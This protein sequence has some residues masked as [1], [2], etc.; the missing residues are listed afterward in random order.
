M[1]TNTKNEL[2]NYLKIGVFILWLH[3]L[4]LIVILS[5]CNEE[6]S[7]KVNEKLKITC[8]TGFVA[9][10]VKNI[11]KDK[12]NICTLMGAGVDPHLYKATQG[13]IAKLNEADI[14]VYN[15]LHLEGKMTDI[16]EK[17]KTRKTIIAQAELI[18]NSNLLKPDGF[19]NSFDPHI[20]FDVNLWSQTIT[21]LGEALA[22]TDTINSK[23]Y[24]EN[25]Q[26]YVDSLLKLDEWIKLKIN[27]I[28]ENQRVLITAHD[29]FQYFG[30]AY[31]LEVKALQG[32]STVSEF[33]LKDISELVNFIC[34]R[35]IKAVFVESSVSPR[36]INAVIEGCKRKN[37]EVK[38]G[39]TLFS[40]ALGDEN[41]E[42]KN[43]IGVVKYN[44]NQIVNSLK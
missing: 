4:F 31:N 28:P 18:K 8:T 24:L 40:D 13:D 32:I 15:G 10:A 35:K 29:A 30:N 33:G 36:S 27:E 42:E 38:I 2:K 3:L 22:K 7:N 23:F 20:W 5:A 11:V 16:F 21:K 43:Y 37:H 1:S 19:E 12:A 14:I 9:D 39:A 44:V 25:T 26:I 6:S 34:D 17:L 41:S